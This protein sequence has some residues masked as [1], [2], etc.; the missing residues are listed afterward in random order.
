M[1]VFLLQLLHQ[2]HQP[3]WPPESSSQTR[4]RQVWTAHSSQLIILLASRLRIAAQE[5]SRPSA[6]LCPKH[7]SA[8][9]RSH[10]HPCK[11]PLFDNRYPCHRRLPR[12]DTSHSL[13]YIMADLAREEA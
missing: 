12:S 9:L 4:Q 10:Y 5:P 7:T 2:P 1:G 8:F 3:A 13:T 11:P 6:L